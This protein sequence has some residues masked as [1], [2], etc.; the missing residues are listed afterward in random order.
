[1]LNDGS[2]LK[3][4]TNI[5]FESFEGRFSYTGLDDENRLIFIGDNVSEIK[6]TL[7]QFSA[8]NYKII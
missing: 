3:E 7:T 2:E 8:E 5:E 6:L 4:G 1:M